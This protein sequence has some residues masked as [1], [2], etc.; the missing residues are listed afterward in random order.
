MYSVYCLF[1]FICKDVSLD[2][3]FVLH[4]LS[5]LFLLGCF[6]GFVFCAPCIVCSILLGCFIRFEFRTPCIAYSISIN[7]ITVSFR[8]AITGRVVSICG[9]Q[10]N[11]LQIKYLYQSQTSANLSILCYINIYIYICYICYMQKLFMDYI[12]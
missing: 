8:R 1:Y 9:Q 3:S 12:S 5:V 10:S 7:C 11:Q 2:L 4:V 6:I